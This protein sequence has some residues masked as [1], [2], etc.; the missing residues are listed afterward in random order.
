MDGYLDGYSNGYSNGKEDNGWIQRSKQQGEQGLLQLDL[1]NSTN[2]DDEDTRKTSQQQQRALV[3]RPISSPL[4][5]GD[6]GGRHVKSLPHR[7]AS[8]L[9]LY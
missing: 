9:R 8:M 1:V 4:D 2:P 3:L 5:R 6:N 7:N